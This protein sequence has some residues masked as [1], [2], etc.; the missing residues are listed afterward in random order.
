MTRY[1]L[2]CSVATKWFVPEPSSDVALTLLEGLQ[3]GL[4]T[5]V[6]PESLVAEFG[7]S[8]RRLVLGGRL[9]AD[10]AH[11]SVD[12]LLA[13]PIES[14]ATRT[15]AGPALQLAL[16]HLAT[17]YD[18]LYVALAERENLRIVT[19]D[20]GMANAFAKLDRIVRL[21]TLGAIPPSE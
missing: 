8:M 6:A 17:F 15:L 2:D 19:A 1:V 10:Q 18:A 21:E 12:R 13:L 11:R 5:L 20:D 3:A 4:L 9:T 7:H 14:F 16:A